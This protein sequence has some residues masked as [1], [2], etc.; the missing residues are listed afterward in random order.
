MSKLPGRTLFLMKNEPT[1][2]GNVWTLKNYRAHGK[3]EEEYIMVTPADLASYIKARERKAFEAGARACEMAGT[4]GKIGPGP[5]ISDRT[6][7]HEFDRYLR[8]EA[9]E[10]KES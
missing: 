1:M 3:K 10:E 5:V 4:Y 8:S 2:C 6:I 9:Y 7:D